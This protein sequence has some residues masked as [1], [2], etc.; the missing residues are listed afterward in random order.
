VSE[1]TLTAVT[2]TEFGKGAAR[3]IRR[4]GLIP[5]VIYGPGIAPIHLALPEHDTF[6]Q[7][8]GKANPVLTLQFDG[9]TELALVKDVQ[10][11]PVKAVIEHLDLVLVRKGVKVSVDVPV[12]LVGQAET[13]AAVNQEA[14][15]VSVLADPSAIPAQFEIALDAFEGSAVITAG[16]LTLPAGV[17]LETDPDSVV[18][19]IAGAQEEAE[20]EE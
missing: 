16:D 11:E 17:V 1:T 6:M 8:K 5:A 19:A 4:A 7:I 18:V 14:F 15:T 12:T 9:R 10:R 3:R 2:R 13:G 20:V